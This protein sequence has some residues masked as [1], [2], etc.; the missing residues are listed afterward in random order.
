[1]VNN[2]L[3]VTSTKLYLYI[4]SSGRFMIDKL[5]MKKEEL[6]FKFS[7]LR[8]FVNEN[9]RIKNLKEI[10]LHFIKWSHFLYI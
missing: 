8:E 7:S 4:P 9:R 3:E 6:G 1:M 5:V 2:Y 10:I